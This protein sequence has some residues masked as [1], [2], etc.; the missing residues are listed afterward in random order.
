[1][2]DRLR[3]VVLLFTSRA[4][5]SFVAGFVAIAFSLYL[6]DVLKMPIIQVGLVFSA[7]ALATPLL[8]LLVGVA[9]DKYG[10]KIVLILDLLTLPIG[11]IILLVTRSFPLI[12]LASALGGFG[13]AGG[14]VGGGVGASV[15]PLVTA[16]LAENSEGQQRTKLYSINMALAT[17]SG[18][19]GALMVSFIGYVQ[20]F[21]I[22]A[23][24]ALL[25]VLAVVP[26]HERFKAPSKS[27]EHNVKLTDRD[28]IVIKAFA[29][30]GILNGISQGFVTPFYPIIF[31]HVFHLTV[32]QLGYLMTVGGLLTGVADFFTTPLTNRL[33]FL[34]LIMG[35]RALSATMVLALPFAPNAVIASALY[36]LLTPFRA[37]SLPAQSA[38]QMSLISPAAR[39]TSGGINQAARLLASAAATYAGGALLAAFPLVAPFAL[40]SAF[41]YGNSFV[42]Y[43]YFGGI[44]EAK[45]ASD[46]NNTGGPLN[47]PTRKAKALARNLINRI[48]LI[49]TARPMRYHW[50]RR[51]QQSSRQEK[52]VPPGRRGS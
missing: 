49:S 4:L 23:L 21:T 46:K 14:L 5:R 19:A 12:V 42:Y 7:G 33:G 11:L 28:K 38:L 25:S 35:T 31:E 43:Y 51:W 2:D 13:V 41:T 26:L 47:R 1:M 10:R 45:I 9:G 30:T 44:P 52:E 34:K 22:G 6:Y 40:A 3:N 8:S 39:G 32:A 48:R 36:L 16:L 29:I 50:P 27:G 17:F 15:G 18:A 24:L 20:L 37:V